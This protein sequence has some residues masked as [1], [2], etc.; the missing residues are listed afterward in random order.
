MMSLRLKLSQPL[1]SKTKRW[2][3]SPAPIKLEGTR[4]QIATCAIAPPEVSSL[5]AADADRTRAPCWWCTM[6]AR[7]ANKRVSML[8]QPFR[9]SVSHIVPSARLPAD[10]LTSA[11][12]IALFPPSIPNRMCTSTAGMPV[13]KPASSRATPMIQ[14]GGRKS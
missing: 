6:A 7:R 2:R 4:F 13:P 5:H 11:H 10:V 8:D 1:C 3:P 14:I 9:N 12:A